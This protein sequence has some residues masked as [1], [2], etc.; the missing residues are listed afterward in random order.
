MPYGQPSHD[1]PANGRI[2]KA[3]SL[4]IVARVLG[5]VASIGTVTLTTRHLGPEAYGHLTTAVIFVNLWTSLTELGI[6]AVI[7]RRVTSGTGE[8]DRLVRV[9]S[10]MA[11][12]YCVPLGVVSG[13]TGWLIYH[14]SKQVVGMILIVSGSLVLTTLATCFDPVFLTHVRFGAVAAADLTGRVGSLAAT[15]VL[16]NMHAPI[17]W[18]AVVQLVPPAVTLVIEAVA[19]HRIIDARP[20]FA[21]GEAWEL[22]RESLPQTGVLIIGVLYWRADGLILSLRSTASEVGAYGL[23]YNL[24]FNATVISTLY[25]SSSLSTMTA[26]YSGDRHAFARFV[27]RSMEALGFI[28]APIAV[29]GLV[30]SPQLIT[31]F[32]SA[33]FREA[34]GLTLGLLLVA[35]ALTFLTAVLSQALFAAH[36]QV[37]L[38]RLNIAN[39]TLNIVLNWFLAPHFGARGAGAALV[40]SEVVGLAVATVRLARRSPYRT[41]W[42]FALRLA[43]PT[44][45]AGGVAYVLDGLP[46]LVTGCAAAVVY[47]AVDLVVGPMRLATIKAMVVS[48]RSAPEPDD[49]TGLGTVDVDVDAHAPADP[50]T[51]APPTPGPLSGRAE[52]RALAAAAAALLWQWARDPITPVAAVVARFERFGPTGALFIAVSSFFLLSM[53]QSFTVPGTFGFS[54]AQTLLLGGAILWVM[55][56]IAGYGRRPSDLAVLFA[57]MGYVAGSLLAY[58]HALG[59]GLGEISIQASDHYTLNDVCVLGIV[60][61]FVVVLRSERGLR[62]ALAGLVLGGTVS[63]MFGIIQYGTGMDLAPL[64]HLPGMKA[65]DFQLVTDLTRQG[66]DRPQG[67]AGHPLELSAVLTLLVPL[68]FALVFNARAR[69]ARTWPWVICLGIIVFGALVTVSRSFVVG[70]VAAVVVMCWR[71]PIQRLATLIVSG[72]IVVGGG[73]LAGIKVMTALVQTFLGSSTDPSIASRGTGIAYVK[74]HYQQHLWFGEGVGVYPSLKLPVLDDQYLSRLMEAG[75]VG[76]VSYVIAVAIALYLALRASASRDAPLAEL[77][78]GISGSV[79]ALAVIGLILD[80]GGFIQMWTLTWILVAVSGVVYRL[81][82]EQARAAAGPPLVTVDGPRPRPAVV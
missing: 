38:L 21:P 56:A 37:F 40:A 45:A 57:V 59:A 8:L 62:L 29:V 7:V 31:L 1:R 65:S 64:F 25:L 30:L 35:V 81:Y 48:R 78:G 42:L 9:N 27:T 16:V 36:D 19:A 54:L 26:L 53:R 47:I 41:P 74:A 75:V 24:A 11:I 51:P 44:A 6:G 2:A 46:V 70:V 55:T 28:G 43:I 12:L 14:D 32:G 76:L 63:A 61:F 34:G 33:E 60:L 23:A 58:G 3:F 15:L 20:V 17:V 18:F 73:L 66:L 69:R 82:R 77:A 79:A 71:W 5:L 22:L 52:Y 50:P 80:I 49:G 4:Q 13:V 67:S 68:A 39:M 72:V 10:G